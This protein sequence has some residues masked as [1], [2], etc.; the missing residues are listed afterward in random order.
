M[1]ASLIY[2]VSVVD[3]IPDAIPGI[4]Y[5]DDV[6]VLSACWKIINMEINQYMMW[7]N[8]KL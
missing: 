6:A 3:L 2:L 8:I 1:V 5:I 4:G 7:K